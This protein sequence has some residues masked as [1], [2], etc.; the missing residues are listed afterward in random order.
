MNTNQIARI[1]GMIVEPARTAMLIELMDGRALTA[2]ELA[3]VARI[4]PQ[5]GSSHLAQLVDADLLRVTTAGR[6]RYYRLASPDIA[7]MLESIMQVAARADGG[8]R[9]RVVV[10][11]K[12]ASL[13]AA[14]TCY[15]HLAGRLG[16]AITR[17]L[18]LD[19]GL[20][21][22]EDT[23]YLTAAGRAAIARLGIE[24][25]AAGATTPRAA[26]V[27]CRPCL[28]WSERRFHLAGRLGARICSHCF[29]QGWVRRRQASRAI[30][31]TPRGQAV[32]RDWLG[33]ELWR[34]VAP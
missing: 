26:A 7:H 16:V 29:E 2:A 25:P 9:P 8:D 13:R 1:A 30:D 32:L 14:R 27:F 5:R 12:E 17:R 22:E 4:T 31:I 21:L 18:T 20:V 34:G 24:L 23:G 3:R 11:P 19:G 10:G 15:D 33:M 6:H 28:D